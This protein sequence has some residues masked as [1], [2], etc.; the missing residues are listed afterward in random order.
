MDSNL[1]EKQLS[2]KIDIDRGEVY[3][4]KREVNAKLDFVKQDTDRIEIRFLEPVCG[5]RNF[6]T[7]IM[8]RKLNT[9]KSR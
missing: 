5:R 7:E 4:R 6:L 2:L 9:I 8:E 3:T 1:I